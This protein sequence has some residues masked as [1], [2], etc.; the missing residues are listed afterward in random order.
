M[1]SAQSAN[2]DW[3]YRL[4][5]AVDL[6]AAPAGVTP[7]AP[8]RTETPIIDRS[9]A[10]LPP[11]PMVVART[12]PQPTIDNIIPLMATTANLPAQVDVP[13][14]QPTQMMINGADPA[15]PA[16]TGQRTHKIASGE[17][18]W[19]IAQAVYGNGSYFTKIVA[20]NPDLN[21][22]ELKVGKILIIPDLT[23]TEKQP[24][25]TPAADSTK[26]AA[27]INTNTNYRIAAGDTLEKIAR[28]LYND[29]TMQDKLYETN[30][31]LLGDNPDKLKIGWVLILPKA[32]TVS[33]DGGCFATLNF[34]RITD[35]E[36][37][38]ARNYMT[39]AYP[40]L[41]NPIG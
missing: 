17:S 12:S 31:A 28:K 37:R 21:P 7:D 4:N 8:R 38:I 19:T 20:A 6:P 36:I 16:P 27:P 11:H 3:D 41:R 30:K 24:A 2:N 25:A 9:A 33:A 13:M 29:S 15:T 1:A 40:R 32:P 23:A 22:K 26:A 35:R 10:S 5:H 14:T 34:S 18:L 39:R